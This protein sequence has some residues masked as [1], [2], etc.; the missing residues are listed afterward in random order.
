[1]T[2]WKE[3]SRSKIAKMPKSRQYSSTQ[4][5]TLVK[6]LVLGAT[7]VGKSCLIKRMFG[8]DFYQGHNPTIYDVYE[9]SVECEYGNFILEFTDISGQRP[10]PAM[11]TLAISRSDICVLVYSLVDD[12]SFEKMLG[13]KDEIL[14]VQ[15]KIKRDIPLI[16]VGNK[17]DLV[18]V[19][20]NTDF[21][22][23]RRRKLSDIDPL[24]DSHILTSA[25]TGIN[26]SNLLKSLTTEC[27]ALRLDGRG[28]ALGSQFSAQY[29][30]RQSFSK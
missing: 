30:M 27:E 1:M 16:L 22:E 25:M 21:D 2:P 8:A 15:Q 4:A 7:N 26:V 5:Q 11:K 6:I 29:I 17:V 20:I 13:I 14:S 19:T 18:D 28:M 3:S 23:L 9:S 12:K 24:I 10:F